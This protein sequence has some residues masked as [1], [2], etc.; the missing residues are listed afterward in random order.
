MPQPYPGQKWKHGWIPVTASA[1]REKNHGRPVRRNSAIA[2]LVREAAEI[3]QRQMREDAERRRREQT[4]ASNARPA[5]ARESDM[6]SRGTSQRGTQQTSRASTSS[7]QQPK[8]GR[9]VGTDTR[10]ATLREGDEVTITVGPDRGK[11]GRVTGKGRYGAIRVEVDGNE[12]DISP[13]NLRSKAD[14]ETSRRA[15][16]AIRQAARRTTATQ[17]DRDQQQ[18]A[19]SRTPSVEE[20]ETR[21]IDAFYQLH[22]G[23]SWVSLTRLR[24]HLGERYPRDV[25]DAAL[26][27]LMRSRKIVLAPESNQKTLTRRDR[28]AAINIGDQ[29]KHLFTVDTSP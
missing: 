11:T 17:P 9:K 5:V 12:R 2:R 29:D 16:A 21:I 28:E 10:G 1:A 19:A 25:V 22:R 24:D 20:T 8:P 27:R 13:A 7:R 15:E 26:R 6:P 18:R 4:T 23:G 14:V 3:H